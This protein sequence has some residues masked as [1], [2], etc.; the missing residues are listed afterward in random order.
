MPQG[1]MKILYSG[2]PDVAGLESKKIVQ[3]SDG[4]IN[5]LFVGRFD[6]QKGLDF[7]LDVFRKN[8]FPHL[9]LN[10]IV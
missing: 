10:V 9:H 1:K 6:R 2:I 4:V 5:I 8:K 7:L 3:F